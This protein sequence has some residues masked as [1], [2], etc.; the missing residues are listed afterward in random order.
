M[1]VLLKAWLYFV[2]IEDDISMLFSSHFGKAKGDLCTLTCYFSTSGHKP[3][4]I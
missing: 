3:E 2:Q 1:G 4:V